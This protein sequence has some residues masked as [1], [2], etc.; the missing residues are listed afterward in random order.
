MRQRSGAQDISRSGNGKGG[1]ICNFWNFR[2]LGGTGR[3]NGEGNQCAAFELK[4]LTPPR[5]A[6]SFVQREASP[7][8]KS[9]QASAGGRWQVVIFVRKPHMRTQLLTRCSTDC[10]M[11]VIAGMAFR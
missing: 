9:V 1:C 6:G 4:P 5:G 8:P 10:I 7:V 11:K 3:P 2:E